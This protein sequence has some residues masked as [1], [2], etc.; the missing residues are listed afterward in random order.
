MLNEFHFDHS[1]FENET[2]VDVE[3]INELL[4]NKWA[5]FGCLYYPFAL[6]NDYMTSLKYLEPSYS[7]KWMAAFSLFKTVDLNS[8]YKAIIEHSDAN[9]VCASLAI[10]G[11]NTALISP[12]DAT[13]LKIDT[14]I[15]KNGLREVVK[16]DG[17]N[18]STFF[19]ECEDYSKTD[20]KNNDSIADIWKTRFLGLAK[21][22]SVITVIDRYLFENLERDIGVRVVS[23]KKFANL[24]K[25]LNKK[26]ALNIYSSG[27][28]R[29]SQ[30]HLII[31][32]YLRDNEKAHDRLSDVFSFIEMS[33]C[34]DTRFRDDSHD[35]FIRFD[36]FVISIGIGFE[37]F[38]DFPV[39]AST[40]SVKNVSYTNFTQ[41]I[42][43]MSPNRKWIYRW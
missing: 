8:N 18:R 40:F 6:Y 34:D 11:V 9:D 14:K 23:I 1:F 4:L 19:K 41:T 5:D 13:G 29:N 31:E 2:L 10:Y 39:R 28:E 33:S 43:S 35:R 25:P 24:L 26:F 16:A 38:R 22:C 37:I 30:R 12:A 32:K 20:I 17:I 7:Q 42:A 15:Y 27:L 3:A 36:D 21:H